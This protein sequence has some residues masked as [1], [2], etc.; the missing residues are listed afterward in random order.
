[1]MP[2]IKIENE[3]HW[4]KL[5]KDTIGASEVGIVFGISP[6]STLNEL[7]HVK[8]GNFQPNIDGSKLMQWGQA[9]E[10]VIATFISGEMNWQLKHCRDYHIHP[11][12]PFLGVTLDYYVIESEHGPGILEIKNVNQ[13]APNWSNNRA[14]NHIELQL[15]D[16]F[17]VVNAARRE[18]GLDTYKWGAIGSMHAGNPEDIRIMY[19][20]P[21]PKVHDHII[22]KCGEFWHKVKNNIEPELSD[23]KEY[24]HIQ[25]M[26]KQAPIKEDIKQLIDCGND[27]ILDDLIVRHEQAKYDKNNA[28]RL[29][30]ELKAKILHHLMI[31]DNDGIVK[32]AAARTS[33]YAVETKMIE[34]TRQPSPAKTTA[35]LRFTIRNLLEE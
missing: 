27:A 34:V 6:Y 9:M 25:E 35:Q 2:I 16:Q 22:K 21:D 32:S 20:A 28:D 4:H 19:R 5:R 13:F 17:L 33:N 18:L 12:Y 30:T 1:M 8:R 24:E 10:P 14:P 29:Q 31:I 15:Q 26:F 11:E 7:F 3:E 23:H